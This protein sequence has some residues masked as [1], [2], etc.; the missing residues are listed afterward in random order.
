MAVAIQDVTVARLATYAAIK[1]G[2]KNLGGSNN[3]SYI[4]TP[5]QNNIASIDFELSIGDIFRVL[6]DQ[7]ISTIAS[8]SFTLWEN[9]YNETTKR[10]EPLQALTVLTILTSI[11]GVNSLV[12]NA[13]IGGHFSIVKDFSSIAVGVIGMYGSN[14]S[15]ELQA[16]M[17]LGIRR[18][19]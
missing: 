13:N 18:G 11:S 3:N 6:I 9:W 4:I 12:V 16:A 7:P 5:T 15:T 10:W 1:R 2:D 8:C 14:C 19:G 17:E